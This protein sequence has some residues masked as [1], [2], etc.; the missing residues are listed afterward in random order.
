MK[1]YAAS[2]VCRGVPWPCRARIQH[3]EIEACD[4]DQIAFV[5]VLAHARRE[6]A[7]PPSLIACKSRRMAHE[8]GK[9][10]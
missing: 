2:A 10:P 8:N 7:R 3:A 6:A 5:D 1:A 9:L 4:M